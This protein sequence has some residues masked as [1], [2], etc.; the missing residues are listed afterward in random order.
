MNLLLRRKNEPSRRQF[1]MQSGCTA[2]GVTSMVNTI[3]QLKMV[4]SALAQSSG[5]GYKALVC[6]FLQGGNDSNNLLVPI[7]GAARTDYETGRG[8][9]AL[10]AANLQPLSAN[11]LTECDPLGGGYLGTMGL[12]PQCPALAT[13][14]NNSELAMI[15]NVGTLTQP[16][17]TRANFSTASKP[18][19]LFSHSDQQTQWQSSVPDRPFT[20]G[21]GGRAADLLDSIYNPTSGNTSMNISISG[22]N[23]FQVS[24]TGT[25]TPYVMNSSGVV[26]LSGYGTNYASAL[27]NPSAPIFTDSNY[28]TVEQGRRL[29]AFEQIV[30]MS[31]DSLME[32]AYNTVVKSARVTEGKVGAALT[33]AATSGVNFDTTFTNAFAGSGVADS[34][35]FPK[36]MKLVAKLIAGNTALGNTRQIFFVQQGGFDTHTTQVPLS[37]GQ[38]VLNQG[39]T[40]LLNTLNCSFKAFSDCLKSLGLWNNVVT[41]TASDFTRT[42]TANKTDASAGSDHAWGGHAIVM[43]GAVNGKRIYGKFPYLKLGVTA[44]ASDPNLMDCTGSSGRWIPST[45]VDQYSAVLSKWLGVTDAQLPGVFPNL[46]RFNSPFSSTTANLNFMNLLG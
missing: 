42:F 8:T 22:V 14:F 13:M 25:V 34:Q 18:P 41:F 36:Q 6:V 11:N 31:Q 1:L 16:N 19:Q 5:S 29:R 4:Q 40:A 15:A 20:S 45:S 9:L 43:G 24:P 17:V 37:G 27:T 7:S 26:S 46:G 33:A 12:H 39:Q 44:N 28:K 3:A 32:D 35:D 2:M 30:Q 21:W 38:P 23:S 10:P